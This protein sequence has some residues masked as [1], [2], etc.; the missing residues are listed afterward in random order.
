[1]YTVTITSQGQISIPAKIRRRLGL[2]K[3][4]KALVSQ[5]DNK[6]IIE[7]VQ[8]FLSLGGSLHKYAKKNL[9]INKIIELEKKAVGEAIVE[10]YRR[11]M[12]RMELPAPK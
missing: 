9:S 10:H 4:K 6:I 1:M 2:D 12:T 8:D 7:P 11:K 3:T 5:K